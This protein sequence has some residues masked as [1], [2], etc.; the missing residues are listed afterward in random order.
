MKY[1]RFL[2]FFT[3]FV[4][5]VLVVGL[6]VFIHIL[7]VF[8]LAG[9]EALWQIERRYWVAFV[10]GG[11]IFLVFLYITNLLRRTGKKYAALGIIIVPVVVFFIGLFDVIDR[12]VLNKKFDKATWQME[13]KKPERMAKTLVRK[14]ILIGLS[15]TAIQEMLGEGVRRHDKKGAD[16]KS[17]IYHVENGWILTVFFESD[18]VVDAELRE[19]SLGI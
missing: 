10:M 13:K 5:S 14:K 6:A 3:A 9:G 19:F 12:N 15:R 18:T 7:M 17:I 1:N 4:I 16:K 8:N 2:S 11:C